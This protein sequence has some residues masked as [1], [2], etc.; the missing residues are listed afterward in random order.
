MGSIFS[1]F[2]WR[3]IVF[4]IAVNILDLKENYKAKLFIFFGVLFFPEITIIVAIIMRIGKKNSFNNP[5]TN[6]NHISST[7]FEEDEVIKYSE[8][9]YV[10]NNTSYNPHEISAK[11]F[12]TFEDSYS[13]NEEENYMDMGNYIEEE[14]EEVVESRSDNNYLLA[15]KFKSLIGNKKIDSYYEPLLEDSN[16]NLLT[17]GRY[18]S[19]KDR[20]FIGRILLSRVDFLETIENK[21]KDMNNDNLKRE[22]EVFNEFDAELESIRRNKISKLKEKVV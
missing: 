21:F 3:L 20:E 6:S 4:S 8:D 15:E 12:E 11:D 17:K 2:I 9:N 7:D 13:E 5:T 10:E 1:F 22:F 18:E 14:V 19:G 16:A